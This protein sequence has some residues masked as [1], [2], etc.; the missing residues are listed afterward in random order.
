MVINVGNKTRLTA[1]EIADKE[2]HIDFKG[3]NA[4]EVDELLDMVIEDYQ[5]FE[6]IIKQ[7]QSLLAQYEASTNAQ[8]KRILE[9]EST[10]KEA[11]DSSVAFNPVDLLKR[12]S[13]LEQA[14]YDHNQNP[15][16]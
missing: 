12:V 9:L 2:F 1:V 5:V 4:K 7:Q 13:R 3:Y 10:V 16:E 15:S 14:V 8:A 11:S 6:D